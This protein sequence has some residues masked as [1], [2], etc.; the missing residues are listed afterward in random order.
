MKKP[1]I[2]IIGA[3][4]G[5]LATAQAL[6]RAPVNVTL[7]DRTNHHLFQPLLYQVAI[8]GLS[9][10]DIAVPVRGVLRKQ[11]NAT[12]LLDEAKGID[13][14]RRAV[15]LSE[16]ELPYDYLVLATGARTSYFGHDDW[17]QFAPGL[18][19]LDDAIEIRQRVLL[20][21]EEAEKETD[22]ARQRELLTFAVIGGGPTGVELA[23]A[24]AE[25]SRFVLASDFRR[26]HPE[27]AEIVLLEGGPRILPS[28]AP[29]L[30]ESAVKQLKELGV[31]VRVNAKLTN[32]DANG[33]YLGTEI[34]RTTTVIWGAGV[35]ATAWTQNLNTPLDRA[36]RIVLEKDLTL[37]GRRNVF[38]IGDMTFLEQDGKPLPGVKQVLGQAIVHHT[39]TKPEKELLPGA[40]TAR[41]WVGQKQQTL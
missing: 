34:I 24:I 23:G 27:A 12:V 2:V 41:E 5:G 25:L 30:A 3:G 9:P 14:E 37:P 7:V 31:R 1:E 28:F 4:F 40:T 13:Y 18:K 22:M 39:S 19:S 11:R 6:K 20:S 21:F 17:E 33:V 8:A 10:A 29:E 15:Q 16:S 38:A 26:I 35:R 36:G 32:I